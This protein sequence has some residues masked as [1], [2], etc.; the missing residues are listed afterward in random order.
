MPSAA[1]QE[2]ARSGNPR[3]HLIP[4][5]K[6]MPLV[7][8]TGEDVSRYLKR[9]LEEGLTPR[10]VG[11]HRGMLA[12]AIDAAAAQDRVGRNV[13]SF[14]AVPKPK[15]RKPRSRPKPTFT[16]EQTLSFIRLIRGHPLEGVFLFGMALGLRMGEATGVLW[17]DVDLEQRV[18]FLRHQVAPDYQ[19]EGGECLCG[20]PCGRAAVLEDLKSESSNRGLRLPEVLVPALR[21]QHARVQ[22]MRELR[23]ANGKPWVE[24]DLL[25]PSASGRPMNPNRVRDWLETL[26]RAAGLPP[27]IF[28]DLRHAWGSLM[29]AVGASDEDL[30]QALGHASPDVTRRVY[31]H[32]LAAS[33]E[34]IAALV[35]QV[36]PA[37]PEDAYDER[38]LHSTLLS[39]R[40]RRSAFDTSD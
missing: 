4:A 39:L 32:A 27:C 6:R 8:L 36:L 1:I 14:V 18:F 31:L 34:R 35:D 25:F 37:H 16:A 21:R 7:R 29:K 9:K 17:A 12:K 22:R 28:H 10:V 26:G 13:V 3:R 19:A 40:M 24:H 33:A 15:Q 30:S 38:A 11:T 20:T 2:P 23:S 5:F